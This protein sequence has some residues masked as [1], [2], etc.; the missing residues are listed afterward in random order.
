MDGRLGVRAARGRRGRRRTPVLLRADAARGVARPDRPAVP[1]REIKAEAAPD[2][3]ADARGGRGDRGQR[4][5]RGGRRQ[6]GRFRL[7]SGASARTASKALGGLLRGPLRVAATRT[8]SPGAGDVRAVGRRADRLGFHGVGR[9]VL[10]LR[11]VVVAAAAARGGGRAG[12]GAELLREVL[13]AGRRL[14]GRPL[15]RGAVVRGA[16]QEEDGLQEARR[17]E[18]DHGA[19]AALAAPRLDARAQVDDGLRQFRAAA[20][21]RRLRRRRRRDAREEAAPAREGRAPAGRAAG[22]PRVRPGRPGRVGRRAAAARGRVARAVLRR[23]R[24]RG[25]RGRGLRKKRLPPRAGRVLFQTGRAHLRGPVAP[26]TGAREGRADGERRRRLVRR[27]VRRR[28]DPG[29]RHGVHRRRRDVLRRFQGWDPPRQG[30]VPRPRRRVRRRL[31]GRGAAR[32]GRVRERR[33]RV[34]V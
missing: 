1:A 12:R 13:P 3:P 10:R 31:E 2:V 27:R 7:G 17:L 23:G 26:R 25:L 5:A 8:R 14:R 32:S 15:A 21:P 22:W 30:R 19:R 29:P 24:R 16:A 9:P 11:V 18:E 6:S 4:G 34:E 28:P 20:A 33:R